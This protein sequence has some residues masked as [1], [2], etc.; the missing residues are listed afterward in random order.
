MNL[1]DWVYE[2]SEKIALGAL[3]VFVAFV[4]GVVYLGIEGEREKER[5]LRQCLAD[6]KKEYECAALLCKPSSYPVIIPVPVHTG[7]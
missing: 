2:H 1:G 4:A 6:G 7:R 3:A 5:L